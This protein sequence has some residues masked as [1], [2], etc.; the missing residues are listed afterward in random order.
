M[1]HWNPEDYAR[2]S[3][4]QERW[5]LELMAQLELQP[6]DTVLDIGCGDGRHTAWIADQLK[7]GFALGVDNSAEMIAHARQHHEPGRQGHLRFAIEDAS[8]L[9]FNAEFSLVF[10]N[11]ALHWV[12]DHRPVLAGIARALKPGGRAVLQMGGHGNAAEMIAAF[13]RVCARPEWQDC[14]VDF[15]RPYGF[16]RPE[17]YR[18]WSVEVGLQPINLQLIPKEMRYYDRE[19]LLGWL[20]TVWHPYTGK[21]PDERR[22]IFLED[23]LNDYLKHHPADAKGQISVRMVRLQANLVKKAGGER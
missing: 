16:H 20:R 6:D 19:G 13:E 21:V 15:E 11:A 18:C 10:S 2:N 4:G 5:A 8:R 3:S 1:H 23:V 7:G 22:P 12:K 17:E 9:P 14:F